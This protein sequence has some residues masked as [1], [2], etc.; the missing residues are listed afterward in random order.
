MTK[1]CDK[2]INRTLVA[3]AKVIH[4]TEIETKS[5]MIDAIL[6]HDKLIQSYVEEDLPK[7]FDVLNKFTKTELSNWLDLRLTYLCHLVEKDQIN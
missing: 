2:S 3:T 6:E 4:D 1:I 5:E 7:D